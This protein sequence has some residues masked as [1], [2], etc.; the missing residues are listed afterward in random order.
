MMFGIGSSVSMKSTVTFCAIWY[1]R[2]HK[3]LF[4]A[5]NGQLRFEWPVE[6][7][8]ST[9]NDTKSAFCPQFVFVYFFAFFMQF[10]L[11]I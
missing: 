3:F 8:Q 7:L 2:K 9:R 1:S 6:L 10:A 11:N 4:E 5:D